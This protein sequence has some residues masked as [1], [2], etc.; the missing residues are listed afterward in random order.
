[1]ILNKLVWVEVKINNLF[2]TLA[3]NNIP[4][5]YTIHKLLYR[6]IS[7]IANGFSFKQTG[8]VRRLI[9]KKEASK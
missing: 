8:K 2:C 5:A 7:K 4:L 6:D 3:W 1:M 9:P